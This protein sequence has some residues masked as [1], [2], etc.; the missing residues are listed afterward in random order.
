MSE[1]EKLYYDAPRFWEN[2]VLEDDFNLARINQTIDLVPGDTKSLLDAGCGNGI[3]LNNL[4]LKKPQIK[5]FGFDRSEE[6]LKYVE[7]P[8]ATGDMDKLNFDSRSFD[9]VTSLEVI[10]H[11]PIKVYKNALSEM[12]RVAR[13]Y[14]IIS[15]PY[16]ENLEENSNQCPSC[17]TIFNADL[18]MRSFDLETFR[19]LFHSLGFT[20]KKYLLA[21]EVKT[22]KFHHSYRKLFYPS[23]FRAWRSPVCPICGFMENFYKREES[24]SRTPMAKSSGGS[25]SIRSMLF[26]LPKKLWPKEIKYTWVLGL[27]ERADPVVHSS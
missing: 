9:C 3:F 8:H 11:L 19:S 12:A 1:F 4:A 21:G 6:A 25:R 14:I 5:G 7:V 22:F 13:N 24:N 20:C 17:K 2:G 23:Q 10:E 15:V 18:H 16:N 27:F 26:A